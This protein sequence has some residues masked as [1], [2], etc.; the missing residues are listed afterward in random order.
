MDVMHTPAT[1]AICTKVFELEDLQ[2]FYD[3][4]LGVHVCR[5]CVDHAVLEMVQFALHRRVTRSRMEQHPP[6]HP[7]GDQPW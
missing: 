6:I 7:H 5:P 3:S 2:R 4:G 1:C